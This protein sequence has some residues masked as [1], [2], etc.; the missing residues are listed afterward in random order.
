MEFHEAPEYPPYVAIVPES[1]VTVTTEEEAPQMQ[2]LWQ[3]EEFRVALAPVSSADAAP[4]ADCMPGAENRRRS[5][6]GAEYI[7]INDILS[8]LK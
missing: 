3:Q 4:R 1:V 5:G 6:N 8:P 7:D 2:L